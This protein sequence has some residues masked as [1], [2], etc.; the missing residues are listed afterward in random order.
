MTVAEVCTGVH[1]DLVE[2]RPNEATEVVFIEPQVTSRQARAIRM[3]LRKRVIHSTP[4]IGETTTTPTIEVDRAANE[5]ARESSEVE[6]Q[7]SGEAKVRVI[8]EAEAKMSGEGA[9]TLKIN[10]GVEARGE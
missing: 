8:T 1:G 3:K 5:E 10:G 6:A 2:G 4:T 7:M 9:T